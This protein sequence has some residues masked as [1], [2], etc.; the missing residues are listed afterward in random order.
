M[1]DENYCGIGVESMG[2]T[3]DGVQVQPSSE[4]TPAARAGLSKAT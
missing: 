1:T 2:L 3:K 4:Q